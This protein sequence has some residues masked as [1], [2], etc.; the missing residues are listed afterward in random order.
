MGRHSLLVLSSNSAVARNAAA[1]KQIRADAQTARTAYSK[2]YVAK[3][4]RCRGQ[5]VADSE[6]FD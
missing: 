4:W 2:R 1:N 5:V 3:S 6:L